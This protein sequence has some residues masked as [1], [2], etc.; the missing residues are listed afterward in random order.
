LSSILISLNRDANNY[1]FEIKHKE[2]LNWLLIA[3]PICLQDAGLSFG[4]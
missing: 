1:I 3:T 2:N 4:I